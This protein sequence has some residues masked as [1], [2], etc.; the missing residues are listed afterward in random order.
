[1]RKK[2]L[3][4]IFVLSTLLGGCIFTSP[5]PP[6]NQSNICSIFKDHPD[7]YDYAL[8]SEKQW[9]TSIG[10]Q[11]AFIKQESSFRHDIRPPRDKL[12]GIIPWFRSSSAYGYAQA[13]DAVWSEY[14]EERGSLFSRRSHMKYATDFI[15]WYNKK[16]RS[17]LGIS[18]TNIE[19]LYLAYHEG[20]GGFQRGTFKSKRWLMGVAKR[21]D[22]KARSY[23]NQLASCRDK[24]DSGSWWNPFS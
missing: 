17:V 15:G 21:V 23:D 14:E 8:D 13:Q 12:L 7:W 5:E 1:M 9:G 10:A 6:S 3:L 2:K 19:H 20:V 18:Q 11:I 16:S 22:Q 24:F 4:T